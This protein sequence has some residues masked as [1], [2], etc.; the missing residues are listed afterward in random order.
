[1]PPRWSELTA[2]NAALIRSWPPVALVSSPTVAKVLGIGAGTVRSWRHRGLGPSPEPRHLYGRGRPTPTYFRVSSLLTWL[3]GGE[4]ERTWERERDW[5]A[6]RLAG[7]RFVEDTKVVDIGP[8]L[9]KDATELAGACV[10]RL[11]YM[12][13]FNQSAQIAAWPGRQP[14]KRPTF[15]HAKSAKR[16]PEVL[17]LVSGSC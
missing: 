9:S 17:D 5:L 7:T 3:D 13:E 14:L 16:S 1:M 4:P 11:A 2:E 8:G 12:V 6:D 10:R 15:C